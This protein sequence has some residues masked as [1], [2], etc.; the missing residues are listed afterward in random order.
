MKYDDSTTGTGSLND[1]KIF[2]F[3]RLFIFP[4]ASIFSQIEEI[5]HKNCTERI[6]KHKVDRD[7]KF[8]FMV[9]SLPF[10]TEEVVSQKEG[11]MLFIK[12]SK[13]SNKK[14][15]RAGEMYLYSAGLLGSDFFF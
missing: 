7:C 11:E 12:R 3:V 6:V 8:L 4:H 15:K 14:T 9:V 2:I 1:I 5:G 10:D 13:R